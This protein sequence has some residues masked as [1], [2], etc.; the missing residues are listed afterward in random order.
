MTSCPPLLP[1]H[2]Q[3][4]QN[5][6]FLTKSLLLPRYIMWAISHQAL[7][8]SICWK[9]KRSSPP[10]LPFSMVR[11]GWN[12]T[13]VASCNEVWTLQC[14]PDLTAPSHL[15]VPETR[16]QLT[17]IANWGFLL[18]C[19]LIEEIRWKQDVSCTHILTAGQKSQLEFLHVADLP[20]RCSQLS[21]TGIFICDSPTEY[22]SVL[23]SATK[24]FV[25]LLA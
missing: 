3:K 25:Y 13:G 23:L 1:S 7:M 2:S 14:A 17:L 15:S 21:P 9:I 22:L 18:K 8:C 10:E 12:C 5:T 6:K 20:D 24:S 4:K 19:L 16:N 11:T